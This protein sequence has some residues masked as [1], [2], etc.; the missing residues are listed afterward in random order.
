VLG[1]GGGFFIISSMS[2]RVS[3]FEYL[4]DRMGK[5]VGTIDHHFEGLLY[6]DAV[7]AGYFQET[8]S[9]ASAILLGL[10]SRDTPLLLPIAFV[11]DYHDRNIILGIP[12]NLI[13]PHVQM[14]EG[15]PIGYII[16]Q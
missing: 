2:D 4:G 6:I 3:W 5:E 11:A 15:F 7:L 8:H 16:Y 12:S 13:A 14:L 9:S 10:G 1:G